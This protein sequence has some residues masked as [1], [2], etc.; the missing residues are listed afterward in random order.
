MINLL[1]RSVLPGTVDGTGVRSVFGHAWLE[2]HHDSGV[3]ERFGFYPESPSPYAPCEIRPLDY[4]KYD[5]TVGSSSDPISITNDQSQAIR[6]YAVLAHQ[7]TPYG[8]FGS[9][10]HP[11]DPA[12]CA[13]WALG[14]I[15]AAGITVPHLPASLILPWFA[16][17]QFSSDLLYSQ[18][19]GDP[20]TGLPWAGLS[21]EINDLYNRARSW[22]APRDPLVLDLDG[23]GIEATAINP[24]NPILFD[25]DADGSRTAT[26]WIKPDDGFLVLD[27]N[28]NG[29]IDTGR[30]LFGDN[31]VL[32]NGDTASNGYQALSDVDSKADGRINNADAV[33]AQLR[34]WQDSNQHGFSQAAELKT[35][36]QAGISSISTVGQATYISLGNGNTQPFSSTFT[37]TNG[38]AGT[39]CTAELS[40]NLLLAS[41]NFYREFTDDQDVTSTAAALPQ[42][43]GSGAVR[44]LHEAASLGT[45][46]SPL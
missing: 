23:D 15:R 33:F 22:T 46:T 20:F 27:R 35:L 45:L 7:F 6:N 4:E 28:G 2:L 42:I 11:F 38:T 29:A 34:I 26:G 41:N 43:R 18:G 10:S 36:A 44:N 5:I 39:S 24:S 8:L 19:G 17:S 40:G 3:V 16:A 9:G 31:T 13:S 1:I 14:A 12:N 32:I 25:H 37:R 21:S 30:E